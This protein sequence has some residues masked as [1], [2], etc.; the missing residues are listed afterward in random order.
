MKRKLLV[1]SCTTAC[2]V[3]GYYFYSFDKQEKATLQ[4][5]PTP[6]TSLTSRNEM[7]EHQQT[8]ETSVSSE[9]AQQTKLVQLTSAHAQCQKRYQ[10]FSEQVA[11]IH[12]VIIAAIELELQQGKTDRELLAYR[13][14]YKTFYDSYQDLLIEAKSNNER[15][16]YVITQSSSI[17]KDWSGL[18]VIEGFNT[19]T[20]AALVTAL[21]PLENENHGLGM[22]ISLAQDINKA[23]IYALLD[24]TDHF[25]TYLESPLYI[26]DS[27]VLSPSILFILIAEKLNIEEYKQAVALHSFT[28][29]EVA[30]AIQNNMATEY[31]TPLLEQTKS[32]ADFPLFAQNQLHNSKNLA[33]IAAANFNVEALTLLG[34]YGVKP[35]NE[36]GIL[37]AMDIAILNLPRRDTEYNK[38]NL[39]TNKFLDTLNYLIFQGFKAHGSISLD[40]TGIDFNPPSKGFFHS[41][42]ISNAKLKSLLNRIPLIDNSFN[43]KQQE[44]DD[45]VIS[46]AIAKAKSKQ[47]AMTQKSEQCTSVKQQLLA[48]QSFKGR[49]KAYDIIKEIE[50][51]P[52]DVKQRLHDIDPVLVGLWQEHKLNFR[53]AP[54][55]SDSSDTFERLIA[56]GK[57]AQARDYSAH[58]PLTLSQTD[59]LFRF[60]L[61]RNIDL[62]SVWKARVSPLAPTDLMYFKNLPIEKWQ[63]LLD[64]GFD[65]L[66]VDQLGRD[67]FMAAA[68]HSPQ[69]LQFLVDNNFKLN[70]DKHG[71]DALDTLL[72][73][74]YKNGQLHENLPKL[75]SLYPK[76]RVSH[77]ARVARIK[78]FLP[79][80]YQ[81]LIA[82]NKA[83]T[84]IARTEL[85]K[86]RS[87]YF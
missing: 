40:E 66:L 28:V 1:I 75:L 24:N 15:K 16:K 72:E 52:T 41:E 17:L 60:M 13:S 9:T 26:A 10:N 65:F 53:P 50:Q 33:D 3:C 14:Q 37:T 38:F 46:L 82:M 19:D 84:P 87:R 71:L 27:A 8:L 49:D 58:T 47:M 34:Q 35:I 74:S 43:I 48:E 70:V 44:A 20:I 62:L 25:T 5:I 86:F 36:P 77:Y 64:Q 39:D 85:N 79:K 69:A 7:T 63:G 45:S 21:K 76:F 56:D 83:L 68:L 54:L 42:M 22:T 4:S 67:V 73:A 2:I 11:D 57:I 6:N 59:I 78:K 31:L 29:N 30:I 61:R 55:N 51:D 80:E 23:D 32:L 81:Q 12:N 18:S